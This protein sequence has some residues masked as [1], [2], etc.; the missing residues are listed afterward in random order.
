MADVALLK[1]SDMLSIA[2][3]N[4]AVGQALHFRQPVRNINNA[5]APAAKLRYQFKKLFG[6][7][8]SQAGG[9][10]I[11]DQNTS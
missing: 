7:V 6:L 11:H 9:G 8:L 10:L 3:H 4:D 2:Q 5:D 1:F